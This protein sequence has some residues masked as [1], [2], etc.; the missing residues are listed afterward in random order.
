MSNCTSSTA[1]RSAPKVLL[2]I[3]ERGLQRK[4]LVAYALTFVLPTAFCLVCVVQLAVSGGVPFMTK[5]GL[6][7][8]LP[9][10]TAM[11][12][13][14]FLLLR[15]PLR[16]VE[17]LSADVEAVASESTE[18]RNPA[19]HTWDEAHRAAHFVTHVIHDYRA[20]ISS[21]GSRTRELQ[22]TNQQLRDV[23][24]SDPLTGLYNRRFALGTLSTEVQRSIKHGHPLSV[25][26][27]DP[28]DFGVVVHPLDQDGKSG[29][30]RELGRLIDHG[31]RR[32]DMVARFGSERFIVI[33]LETGMDGAVRVAERIRTAVAEHAFGGRGSDALSLTVSIGIGAFSGDAVDS[34]KVIELAESSL[35]IAQRTGANM[36]WA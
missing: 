17:R 16:C 13:G 3:A 28:D 10:V 35:S 19:P 2:G 29:V 32:L 20:R 27:I 4:L 36:V 25:L 14:G 6:L 8:G 31:T 12:V 11:S 34:N 1:V 15:D 23:A 22:E 7:I 5:L 26:L 30:L 9:S 24:L 33:L 21:L 18:C